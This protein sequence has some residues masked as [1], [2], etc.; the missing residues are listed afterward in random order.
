MTQP[1]ETHLALARADETENRLNAEV[2][3]LSERTIT[4]NAEIRLRDDL[5]RTL[6]AQ[7]EEA[8]AKVD[9]LTPETVEGEV[10]EGDE[11]SD[12]DL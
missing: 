11:E 4:L 9:A 5:I 8:Q 7:L 2:K 10:V 12:S 3:F 1:T 6:V